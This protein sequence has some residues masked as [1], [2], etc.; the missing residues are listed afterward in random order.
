[1]LRLKFYLSSLIILSVLFCSAKPGTYTIIYDS[2]STTD[3]G[4]IDPKI[5]LG[6]W[7]AI[8]STK[9]KI[10]FHFHNNGF[11]LSSKT[12]NGE[13]SQF[14]SFEFFSKDSLSLISRTGIIIKWPPD[15]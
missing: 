4:Y 10:E 13:I 6:K 3:S 15:Y 1:M 11:F 5:L 7:E 9:A 2:Q 12:G 8:D 14:H